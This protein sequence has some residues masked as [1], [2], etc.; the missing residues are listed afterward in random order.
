MSHADRVRRG[1]RPAALVSSPSSAASL[2]LMAQELGDAVADGALRRP[3]RRGGRAQAQPARRRP[4]PA[5]RPAS[6]E[7]RGDA[8]LG[9]PRR[10][11]RSRFCCGIVD[12]V[13]P[14]AVAVKPQLAFFEALGADGMRAFE[15][16]CAYARAA[17]LLVDR[18]REARRHRLDR[19]RVRGGVLE[20]RDPAPL[21]DA[22]TVNP[23]LGRDSLEPFL[24]A[25]RRDGAGIFC[26]VKTSNAGGADVQDVDALGRAPALA[27]RRG[28]R[29]RV[30]RGP[31][32]RARPLE[33][34]RRR[35]RDVSAR[36]RRG[37][38]SC[39]R[40]RCSCCP[41]SA[42][43]ARAR[44]TS[45]APSRAGRRARSSPP[46]ARSSTPTAATDGRLAEAAAARARSGVSRVQGARSATAPPAGVTIAICRPLG[47]RRR[48]ELDR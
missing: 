16:V 33:R 41:G 2:M 13:A 39:C 37:A 22:L 20:P 27:A 23:Y 9:A 15:E 36:G 30:G 43:R 5:R 38:A 10:P 6:V 26:L 44:P 47:A 11:R 28:A 7:L 34:R 17:G 8:H 46:R 31:R 32:R 40:R 29:R 14:Y 1:P 24:D 48:H 45:P 12:A 25:C 19:A 18:R 3:A 35:R 21:A 4:R 42:R